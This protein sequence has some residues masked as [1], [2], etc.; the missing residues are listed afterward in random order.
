MRHTMKIY[1]IP[2]WPLVKNVFIISLVVITLSMLIFGFF[3][4]GLIR[5]FATQF[6]DPQMGFQFQALRNIGSLVMV[7]FAVINGVVSSFFLSVFAGLAALIYNWMNQRYGGLEF[8]VSLPE[9][10]L[11]SHSETENNPDDSGTGRQENSSDNI[12]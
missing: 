8:E 6:S 3:W 1:A 5:E 2:L 9:M 12:E 4:M 7:V 11:V 10:M